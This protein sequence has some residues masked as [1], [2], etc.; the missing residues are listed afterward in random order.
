MSFF[1]NWHFLF[2]NK[3]F[4]SW[5]CMFKVALYL[6]HLVPDIQINVLI[7]G[8]LNNLLYWQKALPPIA[9]E[10]DQNKKYDK[11]WTSAVCMRYYLKN[12]VFYYHQ[13]FVVINWTAG[14]LHILIWNKIML[15]K[16][17][18]HQ[19]GHLRWWS[20]AVMEAE[21]NMTDRFVLLWNQAWSSHQTV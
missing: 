9:S 13:F 7:P 15:K 11:I 10:T 4:L 12:Y 19:V 2:W 6:S 18:V 5:S 20:G 3:T 1:F 16:F 14:M 17:Q 21:G 8:A